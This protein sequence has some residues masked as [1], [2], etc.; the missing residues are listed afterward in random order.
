MGK[1]NVL[2]DLPRMLLLVVR[3]KGEIFHLLLKTFPIV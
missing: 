2:K 3:S 1:K